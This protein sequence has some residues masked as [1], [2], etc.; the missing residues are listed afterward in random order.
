[1]AT[2]LPT[3]ITRLTYKQTNA[4]IIPAYFP[5]LPLPATRDENR[6][7]FSSYSRVPGR[8]RKGREDLLPAVA[9]RGVKGLGGQSRGMQKVFSDFHKQ[10]ILKGNLVVKS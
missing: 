7:V 8:T 2:T 4:Q 6:E 3:A 1:M 5:S 9:R 10:S